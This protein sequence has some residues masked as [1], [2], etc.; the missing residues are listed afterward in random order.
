MMAKRVDKMDLPRPRRDCNYLRTTIAETPNNVS[1]KLVI[2][3]VPIVQRGYKLS[4]SIK[5][6]VTAGSENQCISKDKRATS[7]INRLWSLDDLIDIFWFKTLGKPFLVRIG[8][9]VSARV[10]CMNLA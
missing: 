2:S 3:K 9:P 5:K 8:N 1:I 7:K 6:T 10:R 4:C